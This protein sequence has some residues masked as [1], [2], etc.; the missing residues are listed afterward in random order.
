MFCGHCLCGGSPLCHRDM[1]QLSE[2]KNF[3]DGCLCRGYTGLS[4]HIIA[5]LLLICFSQWDLAEVVMMKKEDLAEL[6]M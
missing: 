6:P 2:G 3:P 5:A 1:S 4:R